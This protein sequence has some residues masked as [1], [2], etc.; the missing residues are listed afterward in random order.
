MAHQGATL[1]NYNN[2]L[3]K[4]IEDLKEKREEVNRQILKDE[5]EKAK[6]Q[7]DLRIL[8]EKLS[9][10]NTSLTKKLAAREE[11]DKTIKE[12][13]AAYM[14]ILE[15]SQTLLHVLKKESVSLTKKKQS[16]ST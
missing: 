1:Q 6:I 10:I 15:S 16:S 14:K 9:S 7:H 11:Y 13:E 12:T 4:C 2:E 3:V 5:E 8:T